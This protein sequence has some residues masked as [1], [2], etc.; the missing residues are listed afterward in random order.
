MF[1]HHASPAPFA[2]IALRTAAQQRWLAALVRR[3]QAAATRARDERA[4][5]RDARRQRAIV[6]SLDARTLRDIGLGDWAASARD[7]DGA[8]FQR[9]LDLRGF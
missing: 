7:G 8:I 4:A 6:Q 1:L 9:T 2:T 3:L 5:L